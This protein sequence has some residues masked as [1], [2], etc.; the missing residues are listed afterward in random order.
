VYCIELAQDRV[1]LWVMN[2]VKYMWFLYRQGISCA[3]DLKETLY[4]QWIKN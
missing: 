4:L 2:M 1:L 3:G